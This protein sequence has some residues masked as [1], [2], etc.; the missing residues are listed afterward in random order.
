MLRRNSKNRPKIVLSGLPN[1]IS[2]SV[3]NTLQEEGYELGKIRGNSIALSDRDNAG[4]N[5]GG[6]VHLMGPD[7]Y[8]MVIDGMKRRPGRLYGIN[9]ENAET[10]S[11]SDLFKQ[12]NVPFIKFDSQDEFREESELANL[13][14]NQEV[15]ILIAKKL[16]LS[17]LSIKR[18]SER[19][20]MNSYAKSLVCDALPYLERRDEDSGPGIYRLGIK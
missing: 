9:L 4:K 14:N 6:K 15:P 20:R 12:N 18:F 5:I 2:L 3:L 17:P 1:D 13:V 7:N 19:A 11:V 10:D 16:P 8:Q